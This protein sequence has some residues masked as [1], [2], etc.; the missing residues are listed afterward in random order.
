MHTTT[1]LHVLVCEFCDLYFPGSPIAL[2]TTG[3]VD[4]VPKQTVTRHPA[5][6]HSGHHVSTVD[7][8]THLFCVCGRG[9]GVVIEGSCK[10]K[11]VRDAYERN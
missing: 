1:W 7:T 2:T 10:F 11:F 8:N 5:T 9:G 6:H 3:H 4:R